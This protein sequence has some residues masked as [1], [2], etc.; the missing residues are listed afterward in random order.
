[1]DVSQYLEIFLDESNEHLQTLSDQLII[2]EKEPDNSDTINEIFRAAHSLKGMAGTMGS[3]FKS[4]GCIIPVSGCTGNLC[5]QHQGNT[6][7][8]NR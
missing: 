8:R 5:G 7:R 6:G 1:M 3:E 4:C 2:L